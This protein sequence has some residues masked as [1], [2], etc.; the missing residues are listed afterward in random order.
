[1]VLGPAE[2][3]Q[4]QAPQRHV[5]SHKLHTKTRKLEKTD[6][7]SSLKRAFTEDD[8]RVESSH[9]SSSLMMHKSSTSS[10]VNLSKTSAF[11]SMI[12]VSSTAEPAGKEQQKTLVNASS[13]LDIR[14]E[15]RQELP[16]APR[17]DVPAACRQ[18]S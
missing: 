7:D 13:E 16:P 5:T 1:M 9:S 3:L 18:V 15:L 12:N 2:T 17:P 4:L 8:V 11:S 10:G 6:S 14:Q